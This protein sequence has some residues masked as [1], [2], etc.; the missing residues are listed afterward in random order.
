MTPDLTEVRADVWLWAARMFK[1]RSISKQAIE[2]GKVAVNGAGIKPAKL[3][4]VGDRVTVTRGEDSLEL[5]VLG[6][7]ETRGP[8]PVAQQLYR[9]SDA[10]I[11]ARQA[12]HEQDRLEGQ[13]ESGRPDK[14]ERRQLLEFKEGE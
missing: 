3:I 2:G 14:R 4:R 5:E 13:D 12:R 9:E 8:A 1:T 11:T 7:S 6:L 10:S